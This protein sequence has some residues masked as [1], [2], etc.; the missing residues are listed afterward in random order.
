MSRQAANIARRL[1]P[2]RE[3]AAYL[4]L[5]ELGPINEGPINELHQGVGWRHG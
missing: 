5:P 3:A 1:L 2:L 4:R